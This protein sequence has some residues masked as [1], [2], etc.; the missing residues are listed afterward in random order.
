[1][2]LDQGS[3]SFCPATVRLGPVFHAVARGTTQRRDINA[4]AEGLQVPVKS[5]AQAGQVLVTYVLFRQ[6]EYDAPEK[7]AVMYVTS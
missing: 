3:Q 6:S 5:R 1:M 2:F 7:Y 4:T